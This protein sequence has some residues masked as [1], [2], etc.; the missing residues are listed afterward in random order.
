[1]KDVTPATAAGPKGPADRAATNM[2]DTMVKGG[3]LEIT[4]DEAKALAEASG[5]TQAELLEKS[6]LQAVPH[7][8]KMRFFLHPSDPLT[9]KLGLYR[10]Y[11]GR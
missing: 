2:I 9:T 3:A 6:S 10:K 11:K 4:E 5:M 7:S 8:G 1:G